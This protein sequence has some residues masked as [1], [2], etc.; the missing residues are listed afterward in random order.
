MSRERLGTGLVRGVI[1]MAAIIAMA[2][3]VAA[4]G[5]GGS[6]SSSSSTPS[7][8]STTSAEGSGGE[9][10]ETAAK[11]DCPVHGLVI[12]NFTGEG[13]EN[14]EGTKAALKIALKKV[15]ESGGV[16]G[17]PLEITYKDDGSDY[18]KDL[19]LM[20]E[21]VGQQDYAWVMNNDYGCAT[22]APFITREKLFSVSSCSLPGFANPKYNPMSFDTQFNN[23]HIEAFTG[24]YLPKK[25]FKKVAYITDTS[26]FGKGDAQVLGESLEKNGG[27]LVDTEYAELSAVDFTSALNRAK[28]ADPEV[29]VINLFGP[30]VGHVMANLKTMGWEVPVFFSG[31]SPYSSLQQLGVP[32][33]QAE[34]IE[35][36]T[37]SANSYPSS[38][39]AEELLKDLQAENVEINGGLGLFT[40]PADALTTFAW[41]ANKAG[42]LDPEK[43]TETLAE[44]G[45][46]K[47]PNLTGEETLGYT[48][49]CHENVGKGGIVTVQ[50]GYFNEGRLKLIEPQEFPEF[51]CSEPV[52]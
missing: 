45:D 43:L 34:G 51:P 14:G 52:E 2:L 44:S 7:E 1:A 37:I 25:G 41:T 15:E 19:P 36:V 28:G 9:G 8:S 31:S 33:D 46:V 39:P 50:E 47:I 13:A 40:Q 10:A 22:T 30:A 35:G 29:L 23:E 3:V 26:A 20:Q 32:L 16:L 18:T 5:D 42:S 38:K 6:S 12:S 4:C 24:E 49:E 11:V 21:A 27:E 17:C 48:A